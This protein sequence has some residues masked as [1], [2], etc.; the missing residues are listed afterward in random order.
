MRP[1]S[2]GDRKQRLRVIGTPDMLQRV[3][4]GGQLG[5][6]SQ[7]GDEQPGERIAPEQG[8][9]QP[10]GEHR[11]PVEPAN[12]RDLVRNHR[13]GAIGAPLDIR[14]DQ[15]RRRRDPQAQGRGNMR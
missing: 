2:A 14:A 5:L 6:A 7:L 11:R 8:Q 3:L 12:M 10:S 9:R 15:Y 4:V 1:A 13:G